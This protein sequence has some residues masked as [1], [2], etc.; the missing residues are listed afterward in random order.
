MVAPRSR[1]IKGALAFAVE[2]ARTIRTSRTSS[3][4]GVA[5]SINPSGNSVGKSFKLCTAR[6]ASPASRATSSSLVKRPLVDCAEGNC[7]IDAVCILSPVVLMI[8]NSKTLPGIAF[9][10]AALIMLDCARASALP[11]VAM[12]NARP[13]SGLRRRL[14]AA[15]FSILARVESQCRAAECFKQCAR[16]FLDDGFA[17]GDFFAPLLHVIVGD[18]LEIVDVEKVNLIQKIYFR[19]NVARDGDIDQKQ[20]TIFAQLH[21]RC[22]LCAVENVMRGRCAAD[23]NIHALE[24]IHPRVEIHRPAAEFFGQSLGFV[25]GAVGDDDAPG[26][27]TQ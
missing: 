12:M 24:F 7:V 17:F 26:A 16:A 13:M 18:L 15:N 9:S 2:L 1:L 14:A 21:E 19:I 8:F 27:A 23:D 11:R 3:R 22:E 5:P 20:G 4:G 10:Q 25:E 6:S